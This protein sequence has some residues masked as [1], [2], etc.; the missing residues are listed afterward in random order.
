[1]QK[2]FITRRI[3]HEAIERL[4]Q[5]AE[6]DLWEGE[7][8]PPRQEFLRRLVDAEGVVLWGEDKMDNVAMDVAPKLKVIANVAVGYDNIDIRAATRRG[9]MVS[10]T[11]GVV[12][13]STAD[14]TFALMLAITRRVVEM[15]NLTKSGGWKMWGP[16]D[17]LGC[18]VHHKTLGI[19]GLGRIGTAVAKRA[20]GFSMKVIYHD[21]IQHPDEVELG[22]EYIKDIPILLSMSDF[23]SLHVPLNQGTTHLIG[24]KELSLMKP[25]AILVNASRG[26]VI[27]QKALYE[28]LKRTQIW[29]AAIDVTEEEPIPMDDPLLTLNNII[30]TPHMGTQTKETGIKMSVLAVENLIAGLKGKPM[31]SC[32]NCHLLGKK[33][34]G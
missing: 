16:M 22:I 25:T 6:V 11:P 18:D 17:M 32:V 20:K 31:P 8:T 27:D 4:I 9:I 5:H 23:V 13:D 2:V 28:S 21:I 33:E 19:I 26:K 14:L 1:M 15:A 30:I 10:N 34:N 29:G 3:A 12:T 7:G 24:V